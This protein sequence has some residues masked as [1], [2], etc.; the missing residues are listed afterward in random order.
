MPSISNTARR[1]DAKAILATL[2]DLSTLPEFNTWQQLSVTHSEVS[3]SWFDSVGSL[4]NYKLGKFDR[5]THDFTILNQHFIGTY[6]EA[7][8]SEVKKQAIIDGVQIGRIR[9]MYLQPKTCYTLHTD[10][11]EFRYH[12][13]LVTNSKCFFVNGDVVERMPHVGWLY[14]FQTSVQHTA[15]NASNDVRIHL[16]FDTY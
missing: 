16:V 15:V 8:I 13:P 1:F 14:R 5:A 12:I 4:Y 2:P 11:E 3:N 7:A 10:P 9:Y 6:M